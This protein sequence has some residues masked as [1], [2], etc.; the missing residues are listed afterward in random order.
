MR[1]AAGIAILIWTLSMHFRRLSTRIRLEMTPRYL[2][3]WGSCASTRNP[4]YVAVIT[5]WMGRAIY[6]G[7]LAVNIAC[8]LLGLGLHFRVIPREENA[9]DYRFGDSY[10]EY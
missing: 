5:L 1:V 4:M 3:A 10:R 6:Y 7:S 2:L 9:L 8:F